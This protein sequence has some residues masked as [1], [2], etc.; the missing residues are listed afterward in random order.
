MCKRGF[1]PPFDGWRL[2]LGGTSELAL[3]HFLETHAEITHCLICTDN[4]EAGNAIAE[5]IAAMPGITA[6]RSLPEI[7]N[8]W[9]ETLQAIQKAERTQGKTKQAEKPTL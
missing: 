6:K 3:N 2:S 5:K 7:G 4:D 1:I 8:D 9:N